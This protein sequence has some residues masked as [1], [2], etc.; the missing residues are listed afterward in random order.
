MIVTYYSIFY[1]IE[2]LLS[3]YS[4]Y[5]NRRSTKASLSTLHKDKRAHGAFS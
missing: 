3:T 5:D 1:V 4:I 2:E